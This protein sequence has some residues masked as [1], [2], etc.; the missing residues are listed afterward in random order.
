ML[1]LRRRH[2]RQSLDLWAWLLCHLHW[3]M[4]RAAGGKRGPV[5]SDTGFGNANFEAHLVALL[6]TRILSRETD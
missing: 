5:G 1:H 2:N 4:V 6:P 3:K